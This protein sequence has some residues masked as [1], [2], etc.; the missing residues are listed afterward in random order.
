MVDYVNGEFIGGLDIVKEMIS[1]GEF[2]Q[3]IPEQDLNTKL[4][5]LI[6]RER[7]MLFMKGSP[8]T[9]KC[10]F[11]R[12]T[13]QILKDQ[14]VEFGTFDILTDEEVRQG[15]KEYSDWPTFPQLYI[16]GELVG[17]LDILKELVTSGEFATMVKQ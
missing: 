13:V 16:D 12:V 17:G 6:N 2:Q 5:S 8:D 7:I 15:L 1:N 4:K 10:G 11:S 9:P 14:K 3:L